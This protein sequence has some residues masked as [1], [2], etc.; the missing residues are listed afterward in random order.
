M[1][2]ST[3]F[4]DK[5]EVF[6]FNMAH[7]G[8]QEVVHGDYLIVYIQSIGGRHP[9]KNIRPTTERMLRIFFLQQEG[10]LSVSA[11]TSF[12]RFN[13]RFRNIREIVLY[14]TKKTDDR[15]DL[16]LLTAFR[17]NGAPQNA[18]YKFIDEAGMRMATNDRACTTYTDYDV[19]PSP[20]AHDNRMVH[21]FSDKENIRQKGSVI[22]FGMV[23][24]TVKTT[25]YEFCQVELAAADGDRVLLVAIKIP[26]GNNVSSLYL[27]KQPQT[28][29]M[30]ELVIQRFVGVDRGHFVV[31]EYGKPVDEPAGSLGAKSFEFYKLDLGE[32]RD[33]SLFTDYTRQVARA[34]LDTDQFNAGLFEEWRQMVPTQTIDQHLQIIHDLY[35]QEIQR[36]AGHSGGMGFDPAHSQHL[37]AQSGRND[38][39]RLKLQILIDAQ[40]YVD[41]RRRGLEFE[42]IQEYNFGKK[43]G[44]GIQVASDKTV[45]ASVTTPRP[46]TPDLSLS[47]STTPT[48]SPSRRAAMA[49]KMA[50]EQAEVDAENEKLRE[51][52]E[53]YT[54]KLR[55]ASLLKKSAAPE[56]KEH[57]HD[58]EAEEDMA[59]VIIHPKFI[60]RKE[61]SDADAK[62][63]T[64][65]GA[66]V[67]GKA[68]AN[69]GTNAGAD[70]GASGNDDHLMQI[71]F[72]VMKTTG[73][74]DAGVSGNSGA[75]SNA[76]VGGKAGVYAGANAGARGNVV[77]RGNAVARRKPNVRVNAGALRKILY[78][79]IREN[80]SFSGAN[81]GSGADAGGIADMEDAFGGNSGARSNVGARYKA[82]SKAGDDAG[83]AVDAS[84]ND[85]AAMDAGA[86]AGIS[87]DAGTNAGTAVDTIAGVD[88]DSGANAGAAVDTIVGA[89]INA[90]VDEDSDSDWSDDDEE[91]GVRLTPEPVHTVQEPSPLGTKSK[92]ITLDGPQES[93]SLGTQSKPITLDGQYDSDPAISSKESSPKKRSQSGDS[94]VSTRSTSAEDNSSG[95]D[96]GRIES[97]GG[98]PDAMPSPKKRKLSHE[99]DAAKVG[100]SNVTKLT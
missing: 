36:A 55:M 89:A 68:G 48:N 88:V 91:G 77:A 82:A 57:R 96:D 54:E 13:N 3:Y 19:D 4:A 66:D 1:R 98:T 71:F 47:G 51:I 14:P 72:D 84:V 65:V 63:K 94:S 100:R 15:V 39:L 86:G 78:D 59:Q 6:V 61:V 34:C 70:A 26:D 12:I 62:G 17:R 23:V 29:D 56:E 76:G 99:D 75:A 90:P 49:A 80:E 28:I 32:L 74:S 35:T 41:S 53:G 92:P 18:G 85:G 52:L 81:R 21:L 43:I 25:G 8:I 58:L 83:A 38:R 79:T 60:L 16:K 95:N 45:V 97:G 87:V 93:S 11:R 24:D 20:T 69:A 67:G 31:K 46:S 44:P 64:D 22:S 27:K 30:H 5:G 2:L 37:G 9:A 10:G 42:R 40:K 73:T 33:K 50:A 7:Q